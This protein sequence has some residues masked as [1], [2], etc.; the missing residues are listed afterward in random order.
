MRYKG[1]THLERGQGCWPFMHIE[2]EWMRHTKLYGNKG[3]TNQ[4]LNSLRVNSALLLAVVSKSWFVLQDRWCWTHNI[5]FHWVKRASESQLWYSTTLVVKRASESRKRQYIILNLWV[6]SFNCHS[7]LR[8]ILY[9]HFIWY[10]YSV[11]QPVQI[12]YARCP[13]TEQ[14]SFVY[15]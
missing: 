3:Y 9:V 2:N 1:K 10:M 12:L 6:S 8:G 15:D 14:I 4:D 7:C 13:G 5:I 11:L